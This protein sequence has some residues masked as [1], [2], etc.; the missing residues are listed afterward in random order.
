MTN[1]LTAARAEL[2]TELAG[3]GLRAY[4]NPPEVPAGDDGSGEDEDLL[5]YPLCFVVP[6]EPYLDFN[7][8]GL[9][10]GEALMLCHVSAIAA[11][12]GDRDAEAAELD[13]L[14]LD[15][16]AALNEIPH[17]SPRQML[18]PGRVVLNNVVHLACAVE[19][20]RPLTILEA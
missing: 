11:S 15:V 8:E 1:P 7:A 6:A 20:A 12:S 13:Q 10:Y 3:R 9:L 5:P 17:W 14:L 2:A 4:T 19:C 16:V 18:Q